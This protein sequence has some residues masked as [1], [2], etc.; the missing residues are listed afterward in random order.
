[1][2]KIK[3]T[4]ILMIFWEENG[5]KGVCI[6]LGSEQ[7]FITNPTVVPALVVHVAAFVAVARFH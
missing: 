7:A 2:Y 4:K 6:F 3:A 1:M 5:V